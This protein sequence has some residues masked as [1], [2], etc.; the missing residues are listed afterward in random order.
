MAT[1]RTTMR[2]RTG[3]KLYAVRDKSGEFKDVQTYKRAHGADVRRKSKAEQGSLGT[4]VKKAAGD[5]VESVKNSAKDAV[6]SGQISIMSDTSVQRGCCSRSRPERS[7]ASRHSSTRSR[8]SGSWKVK[9][10]WWQRVLSRR[11]ASQVSPTASAN[12][13]TEQRAGR[14][15]RW[16][17]SRQI[18]A[19][20]AGGPEHPAVI[21]T[22]PNIP[23]SH[24]RIGR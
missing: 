1:R 13:T 2:S 20:G 11:S 15:R 6:T 24:A 23:V 16:M 18:A 22:A 9:S 21:A 19:S 17:T 7:R 14:Q 5:A 4:K 8:V 10:S 3:T 12:V